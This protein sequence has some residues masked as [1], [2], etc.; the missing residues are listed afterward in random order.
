M[1]KIIAFLFAFAVIGSAFTQQLG[2]PTP[3]QRIL[4]ELPAIPIAGRNLKFQFGGTTWIATVN[5]ENALAG[6]V[7]TV[8]INGGSVLTLKQTHVWAGAAGRAAGGVVGGVLGGVIGSVTNTWVVTPGPEI[9]LDYSSTGPRAT[10]SMASEARIAE[11][12][13]AALQTA[14]AIATGALSATAGA[15]GVP[16]GVQAVGANIA[17]SSPTTVSAPPL[18]PIAV[19]GYAEP[20]ISGYF[21]VVNGL[22]TGPYDAAGLRALISQKQ[23]TKNSLVWKEG[24]PNWMIAGAVEELTPLFSKP[25]STSSFSKDQDSGFSVGAEF[26]VT[27]FN[28]THSE[29]VDNMYLMPMLTYK[30]SLMGDS[31]ELEANLGVPFSFSPE[32]SLG[33]DLGLDLTY[34]KG[35]FSFI[36]K[37]K[38]ALPMIK[39]GWN[40]YSPMFGTWYGEARDTFIPEV[41]YNFSFNTG[42]F[43]LQA[44]L[45]IGI[46][47]DAFEYI[48]MHFCLGW[49]GENGLGLEIWEVNFPKPDAK[50][51]QAIELQIS[52]NTDSFYGELSVEIPT[53]EDGIERSGVEV[54]P[55]VELKFANGFKAYASLPIRHIG[56]DRY[57]VNN[58]LSIGVKK[59]F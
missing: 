24:M 21:V 41:K 33:M 6:T 12:R 30:N 55:A 3:L 20:D 15:A 43:Y 29:L 58:G 18:L 23:L 53:Y 49:K 47:P 27:T 57:E 35:S 39:N 11:A 36:L 25:A 52:Y 26:G 56:S 4:N 31:L 5:G 48:G 22:Q 42:A 59:S 16:P 7:E 13:A 46:I 45:P 32:F 51:F 2:T 14:G 19:A 1:K 34:N 40:V 28:P 54:T 38:L 37:N 17:A 8:D 50:F 9:V 44:N 10:L